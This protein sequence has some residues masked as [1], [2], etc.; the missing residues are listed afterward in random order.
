MGFFDLRIS[1]DLFLY[2]HLFLRWEIP[3]FIW[4][5]A[6]PVGIKL[7]KSKRFIKCPGSIISFNDLKVSILRTFFHPLFQKSGADLA[8]IAMLAIFFF[9]VDSVDTYIITIQNSSPVAIICPSIRMEA[10]IVSF[11]MA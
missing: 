8:C 10:Q 5:H 6:E 11:R 4:L 7:V 1:S 3:I 9:D 2:F